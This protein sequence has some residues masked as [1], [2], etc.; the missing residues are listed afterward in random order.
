ME[1]LINIRFQGPKIWD[2]IDDK[3]KPVSL[4]QS[5]SKLKQHYLSLY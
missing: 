1:N 5:K 3:I 4:S 2:S